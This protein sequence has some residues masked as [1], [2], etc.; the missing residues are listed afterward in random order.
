MVPAVQDHFVLGADSW[1][2][3]DPFHML[4]IGDSIAWGCGLDTSEK[5]SYLI[6]DWLQKEL[7]KPVDVIVLAHTGAT[8]EMPE[9]IKKEYHNFLDPELSSWDPTIM[10]VRV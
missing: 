9:N 6:A 8:L 1:Q 4:V 5:Y 7:K 3:E 10:E 2:N